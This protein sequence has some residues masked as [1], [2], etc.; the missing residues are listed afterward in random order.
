MLLHPQDPP[1]IPEE[2]CRVARAA[3]PKG[4]PNL[5]IADALGTIYKDSPAVINA[6]ESQSQ[7]PP[8]RLPM[9]PHGL[10]TPTRWAD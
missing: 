9:G 4:T 5:L 1:S 3:C 6:D 8:G 2:T 10:V 7:T